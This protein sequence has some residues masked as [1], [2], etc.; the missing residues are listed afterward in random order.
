MNGR[1]IQRI[2][3][4]DD[5]EWV[6]KLV[7]HG[8]P[9]AQATVMLGLYRAM[10]DQEFSTTDPTLEQILDRSAS[11]VSSTLERLATPRT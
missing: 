8:T 7:E 4:D 9:A 5:D 10:R 1:T 6:A 2:V 11:P 3:A